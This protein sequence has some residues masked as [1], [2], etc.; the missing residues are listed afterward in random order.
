MNHDSVDNLETQSI[1][2]LFT[3]LIVL[4]AKV[5]AIFLLY[6]NGETFKGEMDFIN[7]CDLQNISKDITNSL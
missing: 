2:M 3:F 7:L 6:V 1:C 5:L 4:S